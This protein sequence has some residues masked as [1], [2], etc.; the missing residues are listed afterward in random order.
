MALPADARILAA[1]SFIRDVRAAEVFVGKQDAASARERF[2]ALLDQLEEARERL[3]SN[4]AMGRPARFLDA[5]SAQGQAKA[6]R[7]S[8]HAAALGVPALR[9]WIL[10]PYLLL[11][12]H[13]D[14]QVLLLALKHERQLEFKLP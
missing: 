14:A 1:Q 5:R 6:A 7:A 4:P 2:Q 9:E 10:K 13:G 8:Q 11:Y 12:A 3:R